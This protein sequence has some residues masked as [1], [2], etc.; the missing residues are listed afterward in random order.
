MARLSYKS[1]K[2]MPKSEFV[3][4]AKKSAKNPA[5]KGAYPIPDKA[6]ARN[7]KARVSQ[8]GTP[9]QKAAVDRAVAK[10]FPSIGGGKAK[11]PRGQRHMK[12]MMGGY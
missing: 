7:A 1:R 5:G 11:K 6:H 2:A 4:P 9:A 10:K 8:F 3:F 12:Q